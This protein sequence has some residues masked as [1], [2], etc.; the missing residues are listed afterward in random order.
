M[1]NRCVGVGCKV[2][3]RRD[4]K[5]N[6]HSRNITLPQHNWLLGVLTADGNNFAGDEEIGMCKK[7]F[8]N[9]QKRKPQPEVQNVSTDDDTRRNIP[10]LSIKDMFYG[11]SSQ[12]KCTI[13]RNSFNQ[14][15]TILPK[16][17]NHQLIFHHNI[18]CLSSWR[19]CSNHLIGKDVDPNVE[20]GID[21]REIL[22][23]QLPSRSEDITN[24]LLEIVHMLSKQESSF[25]LRFSSLDD[26]DCKA[27]T[28]WT[29]AQFLEIFL[30]CSP[31][32]DTGIYTPTHEDALLLFWV[33]VKTDI[34]WRQCSTLFNMSVGSI[35]KT[36]HS[37][38]KSLDTTIVQ[39]FLG[40]DHLTRENILEHNTVFSEDFFWKR[41]TVILDGTYI[42][43][44]KSSDHKL[45]R[46]SYRG[47]KKRNY[48]KFMSIA[49]ADGYILDAVG[50]FPG[51]ANDS[52][53]TKAI[54]DS[55]SWLEKNDNVV[56]DRGFKDV[57]SDLESR[58]LTTK[59]PSYLKPGQTQHDDLQANLDRSITKSRWVVISWTIEAMGVFQNTTCLKLFHWCHRGTREN[60]NSMSKW[61]SKTHIC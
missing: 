41:A 56:V 53:I 42:F 44:N 47:Q 59:M 12:S 27:W 9:Y 36:F 37:I 29:R 3:F 33:K 18:W 16:R 38:V 1:R 15:S 51:N 46:V 2:V 5:S 7:C 40:R 23:S 21:E 11:H 17:P 13:C 55:L 10:L 49:L 50:P 8:R 30:L 14:Y 24:D 28:G 54:M 57:L 22:S 20:I 45:Q 19:I 26:A 31:C 52:K 25:T 58:G 6:R 4:A 32:I 39:F 35:S 61:I 60:S 34:S 48:L 43:I